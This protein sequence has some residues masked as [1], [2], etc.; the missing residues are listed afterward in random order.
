MDH[1]CFF[2]FF[3]KIGDIGR[4]M[5]SANHKPQSSQRLNHQPK[6]THGE[7]QGSSCICSKG[8]TYL[9]P[10]GGE[11]LSPVDAQCP[12][13]VEFQGSEVG[14]DRWEGAPS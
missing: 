13:V 10:M 9:A 3:L 5:I 8:L 11:A 14:A 6:S 1:T 7:T 4:T 2:F 12:S